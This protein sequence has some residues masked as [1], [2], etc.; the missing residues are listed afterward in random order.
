M[1]DIKET[2]IFYQEIIDEYF[3][4]QIPVQYQEI[5][6]IDKHIS[7]YAADQDQNIIV[8]KCRGDYKIVEIDISTAFPTICRN[9]FDN[10]S[11][12][13]I[14]MNSIEDKTERNIFI[15]THLPGDYL[16][17]LNQVSKMVIFGLIFDISSEDDI[18]LFELKKDGVVIGSNSF[19][20]DKLNNLE[21]Y[22]T[23]FT[24]FVVNHS[25]K[26]RFKEYEKYLRSNKTSY[27]LEKGIQELTIKGI[28]KKV[29]EELK[30]YLLK[31]FR[32]EKIDLSILNKIYNKKAWQII[33]ENVLKKLIESYYLCDNS[34]IVN[35][36]AKYEKY[37]RHSII[38]PGIY[39]KI[40]VYPL[41]LSL[42]LGT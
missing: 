12:F 42:N 11:E 9:L 21:D 10:N 7:W 27:F 38:D 26:F 13:I 41:H 23:A 20:I 28:Y 22:G 37:G 36:N 29:P 32:E 24:K 40:W 19:I 15:S 4:V 8:A 5:S 3:K 18:Q 16:K 31:I 33:H 25:F 1:I 6:K 39:L 34:T 35:N 2:P 14:T 17:I 30:K